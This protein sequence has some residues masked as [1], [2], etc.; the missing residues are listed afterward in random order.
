VSPDLPSLRHGETC[1]IIGNG[2]SLRDVPQEFLNK[3]DTFG[4]NRIYLRFVPTFYVAINPLVCEQFAG[5]IEKLECKAKF[6]R[7]EF[8]DQIS[9]SIPLH[10]RKHPHFS[11]S[12]IEQGVHGGFTVTYVALQ[13]AFAFG[14]RTALLAGVDHRYIFEG[15]PNEERVLEG[16]DPNHFDPAYFRGVRWN[17]PDLAHSETSYK[18]AKTVF[19]Y[20]GRRLINLGP[21]S[22]LDVLER[23]QLKEWA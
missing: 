5:E 1:L 21:D 9:G 3:Y 19:E 10:S 7:A 15:A 8:A 22:A 18:M 13:L 23:G 17:N 16:D 11:R 6:I 2:P 4:A 14:Y 12:P 20:D